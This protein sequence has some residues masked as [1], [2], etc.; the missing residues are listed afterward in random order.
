M[1]PTTHNATQRVLA[2]VTDAFGG[3]GGMAQYNRDFIGALATVPEVQQVV[4]LPRQADDDHES[5]PPRVTQ[6]APVNARTTYIAAALREARRV[7]PNLVFC[8][9][10][11]HGPL[12]V[13]VARAT[14]AR[15]VSQ[16]HG[17]EIWA[18]LRKLQRAA[19]ERSDMILTVSRDTRARVLA[20]ARVEPEQVPV[21]NNTLGDDYTPGDREAARARFGIGKEFVVSTVARLDP[22]D[23]Y[24]GHD[25]IIPQVAHLAAQGLDLRYVICGTGRD[26]AR[27]EG[28]AA[29]YRVAD[30]VRF[31]GMVART[32][33]P[34]LYRA[35]DLF[36]LPS[37]GEGFGI[38][39]I[40]AMACGTPAVGLAV[41]GAPDAL[42]DGEL[43]ACCAAS[44]FA[45]TFEQLVRA[46]AG[47]REKLAGAVRA[48]F[49]R[50]TFE[51]RVAQLMHRLIDAP[52]S[53]RS[54]ARR[55]S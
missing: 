18:P 44:D 24:K 41:G 31:L 46:G 1:S 48:R 52:E 17:T 26:R 3:Y 51:R 37:T 19:L 5:L 9:H 39:F 29:R 43:G 10:L 40:E 55:I 27:L 15:L 53:E 12:A 21:L 25:L 14:G 2:L 50:A 54:H 13:A 28:I 20:A 33:L 42:G 7:R 35:T 30:R 32:D 23:G 22:R 11:Y 47:D 49:Q 45:A 36:A 6:R 8:G 16:V 4:V 34:D 38:A